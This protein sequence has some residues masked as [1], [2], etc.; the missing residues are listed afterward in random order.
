MLSGK[1]TVALPF[2]MW[3]Y[4][5]ERSCH[6]LRFE[7]FLVLEMTKGMSASVR[8][9][10]FVFWFFTKTKPCLKRSSKQDLK[11]SGTLIVKSY[12]LTLQSQV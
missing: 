3:V 12:T 5:F 11:S 8:I 9:D 7:G 10:F 4:L 6:G 1:D 2:F